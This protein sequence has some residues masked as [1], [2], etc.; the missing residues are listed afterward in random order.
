MSTIHGVSRSVFVLAIVLGAVPW[1]PL[2]AGPFIPG[3]DISNHQGSINWTSVKNAGIKFAFCKATEGVDFVDARFTQ[4]IVN[5]N[6]AG[7]PIGPYHFGRPDSQENNPNDAIDEAN[8]FVDAIA[9]YYVQPGIRLRPVLDVE[10]LPT[11]GEFSGTT[12]AYLSE[13][14]RDFVGVVVDR[15]GFEPLIYANTNYA[16]NYFETN[17]NQYDLWLANYNY[18]PPSEPPT[19]A[20][21]IWSDWAFWQYSN[22]GSVGGIS[23]NVDL[24]V[25]EGTIDEL[26]EFVAVPQTPTADFDNDGDV[27]GKDFLAWQ[28]GY[29][30]TSGATRAQGDANFNGAVTNVDLAVWQSQ[31]GGA[32]LATVAAVPEPAA[33]ILVEIVLAALATRRP[34]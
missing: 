17:I 10:R 12:K 14:V 33:L 21:G 24:N 22:T 15:L 16:S 5:A 28:R 8:D 20:Y 32:S 19:S 13:W 11:P 27:D 7:I 9:P 25:F 4:N 23:G 30:L 1:Y 6:T 2:S 3:I 18:A 34:R 31:Y 29:G 26:Y